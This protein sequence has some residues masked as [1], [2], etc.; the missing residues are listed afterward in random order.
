MESQKRIKGKSLIVNAAFN[1]VYRV[2]N[3][4][5]PLITAAYVARVLGPT[6]VGKVGYAQNIVSYF[7]MFAV[8]GIPRYG[9]REIAKA[10]QDPDA[11][12]KLFTEL[13]I[14]NSVSTLICGVAYYAAVLSGWIGDSVVYLIC[15]IDILFNFINVDW[16][17]EGEEEYAYITIRSVI[18][19][20]LS[21]AAL[22]TF[23]K[24]AEDYPVYALVTCLGLGANSVF[25][26]I[27]A[28]KR[29]RL[30]FRNLEFRKHLKPIMFLAVSVVA[31]SLYNKVNVTM[32]GQ[33]CPEEIVAYYSNANKVVTMLLTL[34]TAISGVFM[35]RLS[36][37]Y[38]HDRDQFCELITKG[39]KIVLFLAIPCCAG[40]VAVAKNAVLV[41]FGDQFLPAVPAMRIL[42]VLIIVIGVC[43]L[44]CYQA[45]ISSG[46]EK[47]LIHSRVVAGVANI[48][49]NAILIPRFQH[50][51]A[52]IATVIS[53]LIVNGMLIKHAYA[54]ARPKVSAGFVGK[55]I[56]GATT[57][58]ICVLYLQSA[59]SNP[60]VS[61]LCSVCI[62]VV[63]YIAL[64]L[65]MKNEVFCMLQSQK[66]SHSHFLKR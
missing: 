63:V 10:R 35:P 25:N 1:V 55:L 12:N 7:V 64:E 60:A 48:V 45:I 42:S 38:E 31:S 40:L 3:V 66:Y 33:M 65:M 4:L 5:F 28:R 51:G 6:G 37:M 14:I 39:A 62:G 59:I 36:Y 57:M 22:F 21:I 32:L 54:V 58:G 17:Y 2:L 34:V 27:H 61:L 18:I 29:V 26:I 44:L 56:V 49:I 43:D 53:E 52:A 13:L 20:V 24:D 8:L 11:V 46:N 30:T 23:I 15:G 41:L 19:K 47:L 9:T 16:L 50:V